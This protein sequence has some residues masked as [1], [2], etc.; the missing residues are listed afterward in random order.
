MGRPLRIGVI[1]E[2]DASPALIAAAE[3]IGREIARR[4][5]IVVCGG[6][7]GV[8]AAAARGAA[9]EGGTVVG[10]LPGNA[11]EGCSPHVT[12]PIVTGMGEGRNILIARTAESLIAVGG[13][14]GTLSEIAYAL[15]LGAPVVGYQTWV[16]QRAGLDADPIRRVD[17]PQE[18]VA[19]AWA[20]A[21]GRRRE[22][23]GTAPHEARSPKGKREEP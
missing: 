2:Q 14:Y 12:I 21:G 8:M 15:K 16:F 6:M 5:G 19:V 22:P 3:E 13:A 17:T 11:V 9:A 1:G 7:G 18:A 10:I 20:A 4:G 23:E